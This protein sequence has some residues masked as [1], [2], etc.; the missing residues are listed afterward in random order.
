MHVAIATQYKLIALPHNG[1]YEHN[2]NLPYHSFLYMK[3]R[4]WKL[5]F[6]VF[7]WYFLGHIICVFN[8]ICI[9]CMHM[10]LMGLL[11][12]KYIIVWFKIHNMLVW[13]SM[14]VSYTYEVNTSIAYYVNY[15]GFLCVRGKGLHCHCF[16]LS[17][18]I[19]LC[20]H[21]WSSTRLYTLDDFVTLH[22]YSDGVRFKG[23]RIVKVVSNFGG[24]CVTI[25]SKQNVDYCP[26]LHRLC[27]IYQLNNHGHDNMNAKQFR[28]RGYGL[29]PL[30]TIPIDCVHHS[31]MCYTKQLYS[32]YL[33]C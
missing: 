15:Y 30:N 10:R 14:H 33:M 20:V 12:I 11:H 28:L 17:F 26:C 8:C 25:I 29:H 2:D 32:F 9:K 1:C 6:F 4:V 24:E 22:W 31:I 21:M 7:W 23:G 19:R 27:H 5:N 13:Y 16:I 3:I 18:R